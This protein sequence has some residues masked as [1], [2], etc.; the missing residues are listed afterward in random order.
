[1]NREFC[2]SLKEYSEFL[3]E[4]QFKGI[5]KDVNQESIRI[6][7]NEFKEKFGSPLVKYFSYLL[8]LV[9][10]CSKCDN[11]SQIYQPEMNFYLSLNNTQNNIIL[12]DLIYDIFEP[13]KT[14]ETF[15]CFEH[16]GEIVEQSFIISNLPHYLFFEIINQ[17]EYI[18]I[19]RI[20]NMDDFTVSSEKQ[21]SY[22][23]EILILSG[24]KSEWEGK[25]HKLEQ[26]KTSQ[27]V[28]RTGF[29][30]ICIP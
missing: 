11:V 21:K 30:I 6:K 4:P 2:S 1:M 13:K 22:E 18:N 26:E 10:K 3:V 25:L 9:T 29:E 23:K 8:L 28:S 7:V 27:Q 14:N 16:N 20:L 19:P 12:S 17:N 15:N 5:L 24:V